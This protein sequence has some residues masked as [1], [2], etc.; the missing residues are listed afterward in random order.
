VPSSSTVALELIERVFDPE[1][2]QGVRSTTRCGCFGS[3]GTTYGASQHR[4]VKQA[5]AT[6]TRKPDPRRTFTTEC[7][8]MLLSPTDERGMACPAL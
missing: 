5:A 4:N 3:R 2:E 6:A 7:L 1:V 8:N